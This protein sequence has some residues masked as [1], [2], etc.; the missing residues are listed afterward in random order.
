MDLTGEFSEW[1]AERM[2][3]NDQSERQMK[4]VKV[5]SAV[6]W[7]QLEAKV[8]ADGGDS[9][10]AVD[11]VTVFTFWKS[12]WEEAKQVW[13]DWFLTASLADRRAAQG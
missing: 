10:C 5:T 4:G 1:M 9:S 3:S 7:A 2:Q 6:K 13:S 12:K 8:P 11:S